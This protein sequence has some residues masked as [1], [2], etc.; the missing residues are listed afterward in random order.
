[1]ILFRTIKEKKSEESSREPLLPFCFRLK[2]CTITPAS[3]LKV[4]ISHQFFSL[5]VRLK[6]SRVI[7]KMDTFDDE[8]HNLVRQLQLPDEV[9][10]AL[11]HNGYDCTL[12]FG[13]AFSSMQMLDQ[14]ITKFLPLAETDTTS[15]IA[16]R[17]RALWSKCNNLHTSL[18]LPPAQPVPPTPSPTPP[19]SQLS[20]ANNWHET[21]PPK[22]STDD[23]EAMKLQFA[24]N[25]PGEVLDAHST[26][27]M[28]LWSR[29]HQQKMNKNIKYIPIQQ[30]LSEHQ[31]SATIATRSS[32]PLRSEIQLLSQLCW[33][34]TPEMDINSVR[35]SRD[36][37]SRT[38][39]VLRNA[40]SLC[41]MCHL[42]IFKAFDAKINEHTFAHLDSE[43]GLRHVMAQEF[44]AA[45]KKIWNTVAVL[46]STGTW[47]LDE[48]LNEMTVVRSDI[49]SLLQPRPKIPKQLPPPRDPKGKG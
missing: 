39:T 29:V 18:P 34:D 21:R 23:I 2:Y 35:F 17:I 31:Y 12:T 32:K 24:K 22:L 36:W 41:G 27:S 42:Q 25:Y 15:P 5:Q 20:E 8:F 47:S 44:F 46:Y 48:C 10:E 6:S 19:A 11:A 28:R 30:R 13:L 45:D 40:Y 3:L 37:L 33:D 26:P 4:L 49:S 1:M 38:Q 7:V 16:A 14:R 9:K 43:L